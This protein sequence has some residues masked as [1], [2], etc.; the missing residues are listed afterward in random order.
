[1]QCHSLHVRKEIAIYGL[2]LGTGAAGLGVVP[3]SLPL[4]LADDALDAPTLPLPL[5]ISLSI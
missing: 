5:F 2:H 4:L 1:M 3:L